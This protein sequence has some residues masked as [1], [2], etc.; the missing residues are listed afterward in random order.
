ME[1]LLDKQIV[2]Q[3]S[4]AFA[5]LKEPVQIL[6]F[7]SIQ[8]CEYCAET[9]QLLEEVSVINDKVSLKVYDIQANKDVADKYNVDKFPAIV[10]A[11]KDGEQISNLGVQFS[12]VP[13]GHEFATLINDILMVSNR[14]SGLSPAVR[15]F[16]K[17]LNEPLLLQVFVTPT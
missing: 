2:D 17:N 8:N 7:G 9:Q 12:G 15:E 13:S 16:L 11:A 14:D 6:F 3:I 10:I 4:E 5:Q 1:K